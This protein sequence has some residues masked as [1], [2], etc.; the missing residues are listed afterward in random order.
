MPSGGG[1]EDAGAVSFACGAGWAPQDQER[2]LMHLLR[3]ALGVRRAR[4]L[5]KALMERFGSLP[6]TLAA[7]Q[8]RLRGA[9]V[10]PATIRLLS[11]VMEASEKLARERIDDGRPVLTSWSQLLDYLHVAMAYKS[12]EQFRVL[13]LD[14]KCRLIADEVQQVGTV[15]HTPVYPR[16]VIRR[17]LELSATALILVHNH[18]SGDPAPSSADVRMT[19]EIAESAKP[20]GITVH[21][22]IIIGRWGRVSLRALK[23]L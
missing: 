17:S 8:R 7:D 6:E 23:L 15:D 5:A 22:H 1:F 3:P 10:G 2:L 11:A 16:E 12:I 4:Q 21:D 14:K 19:R 13:F 20:L 18:P 9:G